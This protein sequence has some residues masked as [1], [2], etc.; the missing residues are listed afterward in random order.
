MANIVY[1]IPWK[2]KGG[3]KS[4]TGVRP[5]EMLQAFIDLGH[6]VDVVMGDSKTRRKS[7]IEIKK[8]IILGVQYDLV[9]S[10][11]SVAPTFIA[12]GWKDYV[13]YGSIDFAF[14]KFCRKKHIPLTLFYRDIYWKYPS[15]TSDSYLLKQIIMQAAYR[16]DLLWYKRWVN[17]LYLP[18]LKMTKLL[19]NFNFKAIQLPPGGKINKNDDIDRP[20]DSDSP[21]RLFYVGGAT[22][23]YKLHK[24]FSVI[25]EM[26]NISLTFCTREDEW[27]RVRDE[28]TMSENISVIHKSGKELEVEY[29]KC[30]LGLM[31][32]ESDE[33]RTFSMPVKMFEYVSYLKPIIATANTAAGE[34]VEA[35]KA[36]WTIPYAEEN[37]KSLLENLKKNPLKIEHI[38]NNLKI[39]KKDNLWT[40]RVEQILEDVKSC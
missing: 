27:I 11:S 28:Y 4:A 33:Y 16:L 3:R 7:L 2:I 8:K 32:L 5:L 26:D 31:F 21:I 19:G 29:N 25:S 9:Y 14:L 22:G 13:R 24:L 15:H 23:G 30:D 12:S 40:S 18:S 35:N 17:I 39:L 34:W 38:R 10:E 20:K 1:H 37:L 36:G 6:C